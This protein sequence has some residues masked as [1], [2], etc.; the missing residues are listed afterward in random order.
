MMKLFSRTDHEPQVAV[1][2]PSPEAIREQNL[3]RELEERVR[4]QEEFD[5]KRDYLEAL[6]REREG[7]VAKIERLEG[8]KRTYIVRDTT[9]M[10][11][12]G[13]IVG[14][15]I[16]SLAYEPNRALETVERAIEDAEKELEAS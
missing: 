15:T 11:P 13:L 7:L 4:E 8:D 6:K 1:L 3:R 14:G 10:S 12:T 9:G 2:Q 16:E 5:H